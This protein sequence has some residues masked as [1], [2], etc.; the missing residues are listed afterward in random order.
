V[1]EQTSAIECRVRYQRFYRTRLFVRIFPGEWFEKGPGHLRA[2]HDF[3]PSVPLMKGAEHQ[4]TFHGRG[5]NPELSSWER[6]MYKQPA[7]TQA[8]IERGMDG[9]MV[10]NGGR[11][12][13]TGLSGNF[14]PVSPE[15]NVYGR[16]PS[17]TECVSDLRTAQRVR[18]RAR[19]RNLLVPYRAHSAR[20]PRADSVGG[21]RQSVCL[22]G[23]RGSVFA[24][25]PDPGRRGRSALRHGPEGV[26][27]SGRRRIP[28]GGVARR[29]RA[30]GVQRSRF[31]STFELRPLFS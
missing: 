7:Y 13:K 22:R 5:V 24:G 9:P 26:V 12:P 29:S 8:D 31:T 14:H 19:R 23:V 17:A 21:S 10:L 20:G 4:G 1:G 16:E 27:D 18:C 25:W 30:S 2:P 15:T 3:V 28:S 6:P 11:Q